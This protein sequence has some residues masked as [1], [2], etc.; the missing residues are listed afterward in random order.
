MRAD[1]VVA[2]YRNSA[3]STLSTL[4]QA[5]NNARDQRQVLLQLYPYVSG[6]TKV[7]GTCA[8]ATVDGASTSQVVRSRGGVDYVEREKV[9]AFLEVSAWACQPCP[10]G[11]AAG[12]G[13]LNCAISPGRRWPSTRLFSWATLPT[14]L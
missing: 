5:I 1:W 3:P 6:K 12:L 10:L 14:S 8:K 2:V 9:Q 13:H 11:S 7:P 4:P